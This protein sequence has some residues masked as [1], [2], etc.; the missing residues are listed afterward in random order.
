MG[1][2]SRMTRAVLIQ[3]LLLLLLQPACIWRLWKKPPLEERTFDVY[4][5]VQEISPEEL[6]IQTR[7]NEQM[8]FRILPSSI[9]GSNFEEG[10]Y[11]HVYY[12]IREDVM[13]VTMVVEKID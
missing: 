2:I 13:Q 7:K 4:G 10:A 12:Q 8:S 6:V 5:T 1:R 11:V 9:K 3:L